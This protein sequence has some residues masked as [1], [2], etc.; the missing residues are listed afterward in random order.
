MNKRLPLSGMLLFCG[1][2][3]QR[4]PS[5]KI[6]ADESPLC[7]FGSGHILTTAFF[8]NFQLLL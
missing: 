4:R 7:F 2:P 8:V 1:I 6:T 5:Q 3:I